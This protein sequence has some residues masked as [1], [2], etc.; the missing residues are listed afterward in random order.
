MKIAIGDGGASRFGVPH[1]VIGT[2]AR[3]ERGRA[4]TP[5]ARTPLKGDAEGA[6]TVGA[7]GPGARNRPDEQ[8][9]MPAS[10]CG[11]AR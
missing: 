5:E 2:R 7:D 9:A 4:W 6:Q 10:G 8:L 3:Q 1:E 11:P